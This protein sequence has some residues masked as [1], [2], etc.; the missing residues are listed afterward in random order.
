MK[1]ML[2]HDFRS[3]FVHVP[4]AAGQS[5]EMVFLKKLNLTWREREV[6]LLR[7]NRDPAKGPPRLA[8]LYADEYVGRGHISADDFAGYFKFAVVRN[9][10][11]RAV[12][13]YKFSYQRRGIAFEIF[14]SEVVGKGRGVVEQRHVD[15]QKRFL[16]GENGTLLVDRVLRY[17]SLADEFAEVSRTI[18]GRAEPLPVVNASRDPSS[19]RAFYNAAGRRLIAEVYGD[20]IETFGYQFDD[21]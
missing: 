21:G 3:I 10:W 19:Y 9:P 12:S 18:F 16:Y 7:P 15:P 6:L 4:K 13:E 1:G 11:A 2:S 20:D 8:H 5:I 14:L 17:E